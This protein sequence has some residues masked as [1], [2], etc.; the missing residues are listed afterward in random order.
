MSNCV[1]CDDYSCAKDVLECVETLNLGE[2]QAAYPSGVYNIYI[3]YWLGSDK[4]VY[5][6]KDVPA[7]TEIALDLTNPSKDI[8]NHYNGQY[9]VWVTDNDADI[10]DKLL[11]KKGTKT[12][13]T[14]AFTVVKV[15][16]NQILTQ[17]LELI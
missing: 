8:Y 10:N 12:Y 6:Q 2:N 1:P 15:Q 13:R 9:K 3:E 17:D 11:I 16:G 14:V 7:Y 5:V 4:V